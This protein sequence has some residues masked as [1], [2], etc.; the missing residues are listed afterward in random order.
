M[1]SNS[2]LVE[3]EHVKEEAR[4][5]SIVLK[6]PLNVQTANKNSMSAILIVL[7]TWIF[8]HRVI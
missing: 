3:C 5:N 1:Y 7:K 4:G 2:Q 6:A 8:F